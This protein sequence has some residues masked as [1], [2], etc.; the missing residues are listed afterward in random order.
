MLEASRALGN[1][2]DLLTLNVGKKM[3]DNALENGWDKDLGGFYDEGYYFKGDDNISIISESKNWWA[4]AEGLNALLLMAGKYPDDPN[5]YEKKFEQQWQYIQTWLIDHGH[6]DW[7]QGGLDKQPNYK[8]ALKGQIWKGTYHVF[9]A[10]MNCT[11]LLHPNTVMPPAPFG[12]SYKKSPAPV[13]RWHSPG[14][15]TRLL[16]YNIYLNKKRI[17]FTPLTYWHVPAGIPVSGKIAVRSVD[18]QGN[19]S[20]KAGYLK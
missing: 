18:L 1:T 12:I 11:N 9:R 10:L 15:K 16:G 19:E 8:K 2:N 6:G 14:G 20:V 7:Y 13:L 5:Q 17:G 3:V 4:Q